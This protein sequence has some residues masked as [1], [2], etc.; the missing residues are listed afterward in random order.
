MAVDSRARA[1]RTLRRWEPRRTGRPCPRA[2]PRPSRAVALPTAALP[3]AALPT[4]ALPTAALPTAALPTAAL[5]ALRWCA[6]VAVSVA[7]LGLESA[8]LA[9]P[10]VAT[11]PGRRVAHAPLPIAHA[12]PPVTPLAPEVALARITARHGLPSPYR[13]DLPYPRVVGELTPGE[14]RVDAVIERTAARLAAGFERQVTRYPASPGG[15]AGSGA[16][17]TFGGTVTTDLLAPGLVA[18]TLESEGYVADAAHGFATITTFDFDTAT[19]RPIRLADLFAPGAAWLEVLSRSSRSELTRTLGTLTVP[20]M[21]DPGTS[22]RATNFSA[23]ALTPWG[24]RLTFQDYQVAPYAAGTP[25]V[26][27]PYAAVARVASPG[28]PIPA[29]AAHP[30]AHMV[31][32]PATSRPVLAECSAP[33]R[34]A[35]YTV[36]VPSLC[37]DGRLNADA[38]DAFAAA[39]PRVM[40][41]PGDARLTQVRRAMCADDAVRYALSSVLELRAEVLAASYHGW[42]FATAPGAGFP[43]YCRGG[44]TGV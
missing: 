2:V 30:P 15:P 24:L 38:W 33:V 5:S 34:Y 41:L 39:A 3:T 25:S 18:L 32:L 28:G 36:P 13:V 17:S 21:L 35:G 8:A 16:M 20:S 12:P 31:L 27:I 9:A 1:G 10:R 19:G 14:K 22:P 42:R 29:V 23:W 26:T 43:G 11:P 37:P 6:L 44:A 4:A 40:G 7:A